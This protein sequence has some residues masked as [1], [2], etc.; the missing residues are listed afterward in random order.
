[1][2][3]LL[4]VERLTAGTVESNTNVILDSTVIS[5]GNVNYDS[6]TGV[7]TIQEAGSY[8]FDW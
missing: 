4:Q 7:I 8:E 3:I 1:M 5:S 6:A 2:S